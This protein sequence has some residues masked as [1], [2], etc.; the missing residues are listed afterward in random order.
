MYF[1]NVFKFGYLLVL[2]NDAK[3]EMP[4][5]CTKMSYLQVLLSRKVVQQV[6]FSSHRLI[7]L[8][9]LNLAIKSCH[10]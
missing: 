4:L 2:Q 3:K 7:G 8:K 5:I 9:N 1:L 6:Y 10:H